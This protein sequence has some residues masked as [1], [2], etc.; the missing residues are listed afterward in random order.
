MNV[1][2]ESEADPSTIHVQ[3]EDGKPLPFTVEGHTLRFFSGAA[4]IVRVL[5][6]DRELV[7]SLTL[8]HTRRRR[9][10]TGQCAARFAWPR[11]FEPASKDIWQWL[12]ILGGLGLI[13]DWILYGRMRRGLVA[14]AQVA[15]ALAVEKSVMTFERAWVLRFSRPADRLDAV[16]M[17]PHAPHRWRCF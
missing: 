7:Y 9:L 16:R 8:P 1:A 3:T 5:T 4:G 12:A 2:L 17:A 10:E 13:T 15:A 6:G 11:A 14:A